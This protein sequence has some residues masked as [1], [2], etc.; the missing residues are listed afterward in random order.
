[1]EGEDE[2]ASGKKARMFDVRRGRGNE[3]KVPHRRVVT[4]RERETPN[5]L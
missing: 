3:T 4:W 2:N 5:V 1:M